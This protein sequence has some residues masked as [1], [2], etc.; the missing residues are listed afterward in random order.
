MALN[1]AGKIAKFNADEISPIDAVKHITQPLLI[2]HGDKDENISIN[3]GKALFKNLAS[4]DK[5]FILVKGGGHHNLST[6]GG[7]VYTDKL[8]SFL[9]VHASK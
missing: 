7:D 2:C 6:I 4:K 1:E 9:E 3:Y 5:S 8:M